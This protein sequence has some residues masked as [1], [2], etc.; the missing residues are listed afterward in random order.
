MLAGIQLFKRY[1]LAFSIPSAVA[2]G[3]VCNVERMCRFN[4]QTLNIKRFTILHIYSAF[5][6][7]PL[8]T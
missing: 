1:S 3:K 7:L 6:L 5:H 4:T 2:I 8:P